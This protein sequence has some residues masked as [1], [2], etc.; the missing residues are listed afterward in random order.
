MNI[1]F[2]LKG[3]HLNRGMNTGLEN[4]ANAL[5]CRGINVHILSMGDYPIESISD[6]SRLVTYHFIGKRCSLGKILRSA[7][8]LHYIYKFTHIIGWMKF[9]HPLSNL[10][11]PNHKPIFIVNEGRDINRITDLRLELYI[12]LFRSFLLR[13]AFNEISISKVFNLLLFNSNSY[14]NIQTV[15]PISL[16]VST[17]ILEYHRV[18]ESKIL[19]INRG[20]DTTKFKPL[21]LQK[22]IFR[23]LILL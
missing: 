22:S 23:Q 18:P 20:V 6:Q 8:Y 13:M 10:N 11:W 5:A 7:I 4:L 1:L 19:I 9:V 15:V 2:I 12:N 21:C 14:K 17:S 3:S 16:A